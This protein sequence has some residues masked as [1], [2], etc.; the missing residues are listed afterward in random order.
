MSGGDPEEKQT[1]ADVFRMAMT[2]EGVVS[3]DHA[4]EKAGD[5]QN[6]PLAVRSAH[7]RSDSPCLRVAG[8][9][10]PMTVRAFVSEF[11][12][13]IE[14][15]DPGRIF[16]FGHQKDMVTA[17]IFNFGIA[18][19][20]LKREHEDWLRR[21]VVDLLKRGGS[22]SLV[23]LASRTDTDAHNMILS[24]RRADSVIG[25]LRRE[26]PNNF[27]VALDVALGERV[28]KYAGVRDGVEDENLRAVM[29]SAWELPNPPPPPPPPPPMP[30]PP[31]PAPL[32]GKRS[33]TKGERVLLYN[34]FH[35]SLPY[36][37]LQVDANTNDRGGADNSIT[38]WGIP[39]FSTHIWCADFSDTTVSKS[40]QGTFVH[41]FVHVWQYY[42]AITKVDEA[43]WLSVRHGFDYEKAYSYDLSDEDDL[44]DF[45]IEQQASIIEDWWRIT[46]ASLGPLK[47]TGTDKTESRYRRF[48]DQLRVAPIGRH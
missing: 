18:K 32:P 37:P 17:R 40:N 33:I 47:N 38:P 16:A 39:Y 35:A 7:R 27:K 34:V 31:T 12:E 2:H 11:P 20:E 48:V 4:L 3:L 15:S 10:Q 21:N 26:S 45:N 23:G 29:I 42:H 30:T 1:Q 5:G 22:I 6:E 9:S 43:V 36:G 8:P 28:A 14:M 19:H 46:E 25:F 41:E 44:A 24:R 13:E